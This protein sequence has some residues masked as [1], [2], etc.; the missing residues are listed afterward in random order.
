MSG[1]G[2]TIDIGRGLGLD[3]SVE[4]NPSETS[5]AGQVVA[6]KPVLAPIKTL[7]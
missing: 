7:V 1:L 3:G 5:A 4:N 2:A 6:A